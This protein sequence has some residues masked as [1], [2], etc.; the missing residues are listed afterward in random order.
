MTPAWSRIFN[1]VADRAEGAYI[2]TDDGR[3][4]LDFTCGIGV[5]N[6]G[7][8]HPKVVEA[9]REQSGLF[10]HAQ[11]NIVI[12]KP[13]LQL[14]EEL[15][16]IVPSAI[17]SFYFANSGAEALENAVKIAKAATGR[18]NVIVFNG[19]FHGRTHATMALTTSK[20]SYRTGFAPL[21]GGI[22]VSPFPYAFNMKMTEEQASQ[23]ALGQL[24]YL[25]ASQTAPRDT[26]AILIESVLGEGG[27]IVPP[28]S[29]MNGL[30]EI[31]DKHGIMLIFDEVQSG[32]GRTGKWF[33]FEHF[34]VVP[35]IITAAKGI[36]SGMPLSGV[37]TRTDIMKKLDVGSIGGT[38]GGNAVACAAGVATI[39]VMREEHMLENATERGIQ[40]MTGLRK[41]QEEYPQIGDVRGLGLMIGSE[42]VVDGSQAKAKPL[43]KEII[44]KVEEKGMLLLSCGTYDNTLRWIPPLN[45]SPEQITEGLNAFGE[46]LKETL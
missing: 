14:I 34:G 40:L 30:R 27:Y 12:H 22:Y 25:L 33:A 20:T 4:L 8:C 13:M 3:K 18:P 1:F 43:V 29:F 19:S 2:Y 41:L 37:F 44:H 36:A 31:C 24:E 17:D 46:A 6:T 45:V 42:F 9:I 39:R 11:A 5:T 15:R 23:Y 35:D 28:T 26:A 16:Q 10:L 38:Y 32:F 7:H 21:P